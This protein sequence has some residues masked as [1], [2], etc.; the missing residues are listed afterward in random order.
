TLAANRD[1]E[2][3]KLAKLVRGELDWIVMKALEKDRNRRYETANG[4]AMDVQRYLADEPVQ[5]CP[6]SVGYRLGKWLR[7]NKGPVLAASL[8]VLAR[9]GGIVGTTMGLLSAQAASE[10]EARQRKKAEE[11]S[12][13]AVRAEADTRQEQRQTKAALARMALDRGLSLGE[14]GDVN[15][16]MLWM[17]RGLDYAVEAKDRD[18]QHVLR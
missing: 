4:F 6:P 8:I 3:A 16:A 11:E 5:A 12:K 1:T 9:V 2:P 13:R 17:A 15:R 10:D 14:Q 18:L 7:W